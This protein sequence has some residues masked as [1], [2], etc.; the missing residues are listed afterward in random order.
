MLLVAAIHDIAGVAVTFSLLWSYLMFAG[1]CIVEGFMY[2]NVS[3]SFSLYFWRNLPLTKG[4]A[5]M[6]A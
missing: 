6:T 2:N 1:L 4:A 5:E 3:V